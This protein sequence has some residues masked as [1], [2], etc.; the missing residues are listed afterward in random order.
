M[1]HPRDYLNYR[2]EQLSESR[3]SWQDQWKELVENFMPRKGKFSVTDKN[4]GEKKNQLANNAPLMAARTLMAGMMT[5][6]TSPARRWFKLAPTDIK[7]LDV[8]AISEWLDIVEDQIYKIF[9]STKLYTALPHI[10]HECGIIGTAAMMVEEDADQLVR[11]NVFTVGE[12]YLDIDGYGEVKCFARE[13]EL[14]VY[15]MI[16][17]FGMDAVSENVRQMYNAGNLSQKFT[18]RHIIEPNDKG[19][20]AIS[21]NPKFKFRSVF[22]EKQCPE[23][24]KWLSLK[25]YVSFPVLA[26]RW[27]TKPGDVYG[28]GPGMEALGDAIKLQ[29]QERQK[30]TG[31]ATQ[32]KPPVVA[33]GTG[34]GKRVSILPGAINYVAESSNAQLKPVF[35]SNIQ[36]E[37]LL[38]DIAVC[39]QKIQEAFFSNLFLM[40][41][42][43]TRKQRATATE[44]DERREEKLLM[45]G[46]VLENLNSELLDPL[47]QRV[48][49]ILVRASEPYWN[50]I[51]KVGYLPPPP[52]ELQGKPLSVEYISMLSLAQKANS[53]AAIERI[54][55][56][57]GEAAALNPEILDNLDFDEIVAVLAKDLGVPTK[58][59]LSKEDVQFL[60]E[61]RAE[62][63]QQLEMAAQMPQQAQAV[64]NFAEAANNMQG[65][66][67]GSLADMVRSNAGL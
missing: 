52:E 28:I 4:K 2:F 35:L 53:T 63:Q 46:P 17:R 19:R 41:I 55:A 8:P 60:R 13:F 5:G 64:K 59:V 18:V 24:D 26:P 34:S 49:E 37:H 51:E 58:V 54:V 31:I 65:E 20:G 38:A 36:L 3:S 62:Q 1:F 15:E 42:N 25:G 27:I 12:Y 45:L 10:Y 6:V 61:Q 11:F 7:M 33:T 43:D 66:Q 21:I 14:T 57:T 47:I 40:V 67:Q 48:F 9:A 32:V 30:G 44:I 29:I 16:T 56:F 50:G 23:R 22:F 39:E